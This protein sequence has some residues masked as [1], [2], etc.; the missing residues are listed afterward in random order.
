MDNYSNLRV[1]LLLRYYRQYR[2]YQLHMA[3]Y[4]VTEMDRTALTKQHTSQ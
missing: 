3:H 4:V 2:E 1:L